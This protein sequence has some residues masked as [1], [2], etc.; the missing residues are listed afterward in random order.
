MIILPSK[1]FSKNNDCAG[2]GDLGLAYYDV[3]IPMLIVTAAV[4]YNN[5]KGKK[6]QVLYSIIKTDFLRLTSEI[7]CWLVTSYDYDII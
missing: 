5:Y 1:N 4:K 7:I 2:N 3:E 6:F